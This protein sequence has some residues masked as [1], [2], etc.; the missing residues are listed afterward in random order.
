MAV[1]T[2]GVDIIDVKILDVDTALDNGFV[3]V[4]WMHIDV[5]SSLLSEDAFNYFKEGECAYLYIQMKLRMR[6][7]LFYGLMRRKIFC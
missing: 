3:E 5:N 7:E 1:N 6:R 4:G 2:L